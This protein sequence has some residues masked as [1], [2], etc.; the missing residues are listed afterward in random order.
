MKYVSMTSYCGN[1]LKKS[2]ET[3]NDLITYREITACN[4]RN[5]VFANTKSVL[6]LTDK[7]F[8]I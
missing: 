3:A 2:G 6:L 7:M 5:P 1:C 4:S 8:R